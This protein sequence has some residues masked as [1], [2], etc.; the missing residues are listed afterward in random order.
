MCC[1]LN[2]HLTGHIKAD[3]ANGPQRYFKTYA[4]KQFDDS[5]EFLLSSPI[6]RVFVPID[7]SGVIHSDRSAF[8]LSLFYLTGAERRKASIAVNEEARGTRDQLKP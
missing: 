7:G 8:N 2:N 3:L 5:D 1:N 4:V 6:Q